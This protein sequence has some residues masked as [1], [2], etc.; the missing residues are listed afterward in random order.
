MLNYVWPIVL[1][2]LSNV[3]YQICAKSVPEGMNP[4][5]SLTV[6]YLIGAVVSFALYYI[7]GKDANIIK[8]Y[9]QINWAPFVLG[10]VIV[11]LEV[12]YIYAYKAGWQVSTAQIVQAALVA[13]VLVFVG[14]GLYHEALSLKKI[15]GIV[16]CLSGLVLINI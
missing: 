9:S 2:I 6:T 5:A 10:F 7:L 12:G 1:V 16:I 13:I 15:A 8:E 3:F 14:Y 4:L 11:G